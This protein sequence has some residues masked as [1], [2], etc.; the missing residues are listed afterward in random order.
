MAN[1]TEVLHTP[2][3]ERFDYYVSPLDLFIPPNMKV[4]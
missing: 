2:G 4:N 3:P 1:S